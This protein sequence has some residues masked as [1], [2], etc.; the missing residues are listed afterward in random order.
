M[1]KAGMMAFGAGV[2]MMAALVATGANAAVCKS[3][4]S[5]SG[6]GTG[7][8]GAGTENAKASAIATFES[9][10]GTRY[11]KRFSNFG[12]AKSIN[13]DCKSTLSK[14]KCVVTAKPCK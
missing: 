10:A 4:I 8:F 7:V 11:G 14:A 3:R 12:K 6:I 1:R 5:G 2:A 13:W 9:R